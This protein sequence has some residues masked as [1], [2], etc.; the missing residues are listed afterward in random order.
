MK[1]KYESDSN[2]IL[3]VLW[4]ADARH[5]TIAWITSLKLLQQYSVSEVRSSVAYSL[6]IKIQTNNATNKSKEILPCCNTVKPK[7]PPNGMAKKVTV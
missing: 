4:K 3:T 2:T 6:Q 5:Y 7:Q 1:Y